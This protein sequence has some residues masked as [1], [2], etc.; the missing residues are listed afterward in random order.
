MPLHSWGRQGSIYATMVC[1]VLCISHWVLL[2]LLLLLLLLPRC[3]LLLQP[4]HMFLVQKR[5][6]ISEQDI[7]SLHAQLQ[8][9]G[10]AHLVGMR[11]QLTGTTAGLLFIPC[12]VC[13]KDAPNMQVHK[14]PLTASQP[15][16]GTQPKKA[17]V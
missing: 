14:L 17:R 5:K 11:L 16:R 4:P 2:L 10:R 12:T 6:Q 15:L 3:N 9:A 1:P 8:A 7:C 13:A